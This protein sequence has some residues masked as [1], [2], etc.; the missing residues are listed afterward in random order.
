[1]ITRVAA[2][3]A[4]AAALFAIDPPGL[5][6]VLL[7][8]R[9]G[10]ERDSWLALLRS[11]LPSGTP[12]R[13][14]PLAINDTA[15][16]GGLDLGAT[17]QAG[18]PVARL[19]ALAQADGGV[20]MLAMAERIEAGPAARLTAV[21]DTHTVR[22]ERDGLAV[23]HPARLGVVALDEGI[24]DDERPRAALVDR[25]AFQPSLVMVPAS[26][27]PWQLADIEAAR[28]VLPRVTA[29]DAV[30]QALCAAADALG[31][32]S[33]RGPLLALRAARAAAALSGETQ[34]RE[35]HAALAARLVLAPRATRLPQAEAP[36]EDAES[37]DTDVDDM[38]AADGAEETE[39]NAAPDL[40]E[41]S[42][43]PDE[44]SRSGEARAEELASSVLEAA[45]AA[46]P[47]GLLAALQPGQTHRDRAQAGGRAGAP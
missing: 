23:L 19:G 4:T 37:A 13:R 25:L 27:D 9:A 2:D 11:L 33:L 41:A 31:V 30:L 14:I 29:S 47:A 35:E 42:E 26:G 12:W 7:R 21:L 40:S 45:R 1:M 5:G 22:L 8:A 28:A 34:V 16:L 20:V 46:I 43:G 15:L 10:P 6:G 32:A 38:D 17:L 36:A 24:E 3:A 18:Q 39:D 44:D